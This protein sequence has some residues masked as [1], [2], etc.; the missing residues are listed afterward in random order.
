MVDCGARAVALCG[1]RQTAVNVSTSR[2]YLIG[3]CFKSPSK[4]RCIERVVE[5]IAQ[6]CRFAA[7]YVRDEFGTPA[8]EEILNSGFVRASP[9]QRH[10]IHIPPIHL[11]NRV[12][13][14][15]RRI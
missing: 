12:S 1:Q 15:A 2:L 7:F 4:D 14:V 13:L 6:Q 11:P 9:G 3:M 8:K 10:L 5:A